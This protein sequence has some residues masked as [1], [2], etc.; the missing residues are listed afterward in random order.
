MLQWIKKSLRNIVRWLLE[1]E[2]PLSL[3]LEVSS[4]CPGALPTKMK[5]VGVQGLALVCENPA[6][7]ERLVRMEDAADEQ[8]WLRLYRILGGANP[9]WP[10]GTPYFADFHGPGRQF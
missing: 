4:G 1:D 9:R 8:H 6:G 2:V 7:G 5:A 3:L 10:D